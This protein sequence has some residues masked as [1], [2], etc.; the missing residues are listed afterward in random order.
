M[1]IL[2]LHIA[3]FGKFT[4]KRLDLAQGIA[5]IK[6]ENGW[7]KTTLARFIEC[8]FYGLDGDKKQ[9][10][11]ENDRKK[12]APWSGGTFGG[13]LIFEYKNK[14]YRIER[15]FGK[16]A[17]GDSAH[18][19][20]S[21]RML[22][23]DFGDRVQNLGETLFGVDRESFRRSVYIPQGE[24]RTDGFTGGIREKLQAV[25]V[26]GGSLDNRDAV[27]ILD[28]A[29]KALRSRRAPKKGKLDCIDE[30]LL[31]L[32][33]EKTECDQ[34]ARLAEEQRQ[35]VQ[36]ADENLQ[37]LDGAIARVDSD[38]E[39]CRKAEAQAATERAY[40]Q[41]LQ[42]VTDAEKR[43]EHL[44]AFFGDVSPET[45][46]TQGLKNAI[47][48]YYQAL[49]ECKTLQEQTDGLE[50]KRESLERKKERRF[51]C[52]K[53]LETFALMLRAQEENKGA[54]MRPKG[55]N[56]KKR[57]GN[58]SAFILFALGAAALLF[59]GWEIGKN[60][61]WG[62]AAVLCGGAAALYSVG[63]WLRN[64]F[65]RKRKKSG[66]FVDKQ[67]DEN[68]KATLNEKALLDEE[69][70]ELENALRGKESAN[71]REK[72]EHAQKWEQAVKNFLHNFRFEEIYDYR[73]AY[74]TLVDNIQAY[75]SCRKTLESKGELQGY[76]SAEELPDVE[77]LESLQAKRK[78]LFAQRE[79]CTAERAA[80]QT[81]A[82]TLENSAAKKA[83]VDSEEE[84]LLATQK[85]LETRLRAIRTAKELLTRARNAMAAKYLEPVE[86]ACRRYLQVMGYT[87]A[88]GVRFQSDGIPVLEVN[89]IFRDAEYY[90]AGGKGLLDFCIR[91]A[92][93]ENM[94]QGELPP[95][96]LDDPFTDLD[97][98]KTER[99]KALVKELAR[100]YQILY[101]TC[102]QE[103][104][105]G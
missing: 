86:N 36:R 100:K 90:S 15:L 95:L 73:A 4:D 54:G 8:M 82:E 18:L 66:D 101:F 14:T 19:Y 97:D 34:Q 41:L 78:E 16:T 13:S 9:N 79:A 104:T 10:V 25:L 37:E 51:S 102:K 43:M 28:E 12:Y 85:R 60:V 80:A 69:I 23:Y 59:G 74:N 24:I 38:I 52:E 64:A 61:L 77:S 98:E 67:L 46:N 65:S 81:R 22:C 6:A 92:L 63:V 26:G 75:I 53:Q 62:G 39:I 21:N 33:Q 40:G 7:G 68:Y 48:A 42:S 103:R 87:Q 49:E 30:R 17:G 29:D 84:R 5:Q 93:A 71:V 1:K 105:L 50:R 58:V 11:A 47:D 88:N 99:A 35:I 83:D 2:S 55:E 96:I 27:Q 56:P 70:G 72:Q 76:F 45:V 91:I 3:G 20:D 32:A 31:Q 94:F 57:M 89:G 44:R